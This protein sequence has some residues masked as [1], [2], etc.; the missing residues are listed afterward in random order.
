MLLASASR[1]VRNAAISA[2]FGKTH[3]A[4]KSAIATA[5]AVTPSV[6][7]VTRASAGRFKACRPATAP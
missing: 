2:G 3:Q 7:N 4:T 6:Q 5:I 1:S